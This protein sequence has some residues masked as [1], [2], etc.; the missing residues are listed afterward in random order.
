[1][2]PP[3]APLSVGFGAVVA[4]G[5]GV[6]AGADFAAGFFFGSV[7]AA[8]ASAAADMKTTRAADAIVL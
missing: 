6:E 3:C 7:S 1:M 4:A 2:M 8:S 5:A